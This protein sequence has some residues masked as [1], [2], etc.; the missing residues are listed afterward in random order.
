M[1][2]EL[3]NVTKRFGATTALDRVDLVIPDG[4]RV[5]LLGPNG[6]GKSTL[7]RA[8]MG[9]VRCQGDILVDGRPVAERREVASRL[10]YVAQ[11]SP[12]LAAPVEEVVR[13]VTALRGLDPDAIDDAAADLGLELRRIARCAVRGLSGGM[14]QKLF[15]ALALATPADLLI[16]DEPTASL[17]A[18]TRARA[19]TRIAA[20][21]ANATVILCSHRLDE[22]RA[23]VDHVVVLADGRPV[24]DEPADAYLAAHQA[25][26][27]ELRYRGDDTA[28]LTQH[29]FVA[30]ATGWWTRPVSPAEKLQL[31]PG[32]IARLGPA[33]EDV[34]M[35][36]T[37]RVELQVNHAA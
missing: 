6:S 21:A 35:R 33:L 10:A 16:F 12:L 4:A 2:I 3:R 26:V 7:T 11:T 9:L 34:V 23:I 28:W 5:A 22:L 8:I 13:A 36:E 14:R 17:D 31:L 20:R 1:R 37:E 18:A 24:H 19:L 32:L 25:A 30:R 29:G 27:L 15:L